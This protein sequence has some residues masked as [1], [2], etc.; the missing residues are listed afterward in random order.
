MTEEGEFPEVATGPDGSDR[1]SRLNHLHLPGAD[2]VE[3]IADV[4]LP[5]QLLPGNR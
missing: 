5:D 1:G 2:R 3:G 4:T